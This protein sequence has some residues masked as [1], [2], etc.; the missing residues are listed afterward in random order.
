LVSSACEGIQQYAI[1][2][3]RALEPLRCAKDIEPSKSAR[4]K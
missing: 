3:Q 2:E 4:R 1:S